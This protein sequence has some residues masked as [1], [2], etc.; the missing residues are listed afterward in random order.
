MAAITCCSRFSPG[1][2]FSPS[3]AVEVEDVEAGESTERFAARS[4]AGDGPE[5]NAMM[6]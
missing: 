6:L 2:R 5:K 1:L 4:V 3:W